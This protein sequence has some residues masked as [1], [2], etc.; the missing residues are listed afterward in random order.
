[1]HP[2]KKGGINL[3]SA[4]RT[5][6]SACKIFDGEDLCKYIYIRCIYSIIYIQ[7]YK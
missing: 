7:R 4:D 6:I 3:G 1:M 5:D 2:G